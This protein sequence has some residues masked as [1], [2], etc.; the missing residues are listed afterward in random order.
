V[1][2][3]LIALA[4]EIKQANLNVSMLQQKFDPQDIDSTNLIIP[5]GQYSTNIYSDDPQ[6]NLL[7]SSDQFEVNSISL[8]F[9]VLL[10]CFANCF[11]SL[12]FFSSSNFSGC[13]SQ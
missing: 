8:V 6:M 3:K 1:D 13:Q 9:F 10:F 4:A 12:F 11:F 7:I 2:E 5:D